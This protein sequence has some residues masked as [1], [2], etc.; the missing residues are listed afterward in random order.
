MLSR[1]EVANMSDMGL[2]LTFDRLADRLSQDWRRGAPGKLS[3][4]YDLALIRCEADLRCLPI[5]PLPHQGRLFPVDA[6]V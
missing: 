4:V 6:A 5:S 3:D 2:Q 1:A